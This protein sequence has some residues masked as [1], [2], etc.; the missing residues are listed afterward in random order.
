MS[1]DCSHARIVPE[2]RY[3][4]VDEAVVTCPG[5][6]ESCGADVEIIYRRDEVV[7]H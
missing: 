4:D 1:D 6:C 7:E 2:T 5:T 3:A